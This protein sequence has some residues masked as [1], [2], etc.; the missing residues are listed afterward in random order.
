MVFTSKE[1]EAINSLMVKLM[2]ADGHTDISEA[3]K[4]FEISKIID[5]N[6]NE[7]DKSLHIPFDKAKVTLQSMNSDKK[8]FVKD[9]FNS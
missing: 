7:A 6:I 8:E 1:K 3:I 5:I 9:L 4:L 2:K